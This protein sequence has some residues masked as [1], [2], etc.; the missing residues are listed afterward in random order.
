[1]VKYLTEIKISKGNQPEN[2]YQQFMGVL[3]VSLE[4]L[5]FS[6]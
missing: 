3:F 2:Q 6:F 1:M 5:S 4:F